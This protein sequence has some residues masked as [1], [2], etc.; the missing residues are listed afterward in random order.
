VVRAIGGGIEPDHARGPRVVTAAVEQQQLNPVAVFEKTLK[1]VPSWLGV[2]PSGALLP[3][4]V[5]LW[6]AS[7]RIGDRADSS[8][9]VTARSVVRI[10]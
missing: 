2:A 10:G 8:I 6:D 9:V 3:G 4:F 7:A 1:F 5:R